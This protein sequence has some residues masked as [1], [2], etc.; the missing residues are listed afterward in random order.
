MSNL[1]GGN[2]IVGLDIGTS[3][4]V[5]I[6]GEINPE[7]GLNIVGIG[8]HRSRGLKKGTVVNIESTVQSI[9]RAVEEAELMAG[10]QIHSVY[11]GIAGSHVRSMNSHGIVAIRDKEVYP[12]DIER[13]IDA[14][15]AVAI[16][17][18]Q[19]VL[20]ILPQEYIIDSQEGV[21]EPLGMSGVRLEAKVHLVT[22]A[23]N[24]AQNI[25]K[26]IKR[27]G[28]ET[29][30]IILEQLA[31]SYSVLTEDEKEL[32]VCLVDIGGGTTDIAIFTEGAIRHT[33]VIPIA[34]DQ[35]TNDIA[36]A[37]RTPTDNA[38]ELKIKYACALS[39]LAS[40]DDMIKVP[41]VGERPPRE[42]SRQALADVVEPRYDELFHLI[43]AE[44]RQS[45]YEDMMAAGMVFTGGTSKME[46]VAEL[47]EEIF[48]MPVR[49]GVPNDV[50]GLVDIVRN[51]TYSTAVGL[52]LYGVQQAHE[53][54]G[55]ATRE[56]GV[57]LFDKVK[58]IF[59]S[60]D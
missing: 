27:C 19:K 56:P 16:P 4:V 42:L 7:G 50:S 55:L 36:M 9:Q 1:N 37:L 12:A 43:Q 39:Q 10:C 17:A 41:S 5:A 40:E 31:S 38:E 60:E 22:C 11:A 25:E 35:V 24:A 6:V 33:G 51:P 30:E 2:M 48:H 54:V 47:A 15:Q 53:R 13:V 32:G 3:K 14:A 20:H 28:L 49:I 52:L 45:G 23:T 21:K 18:D 34:G 57:S 8:R 26:C 29:D 44:I 58:S 59:S 46:G